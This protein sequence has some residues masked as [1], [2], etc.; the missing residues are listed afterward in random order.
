MPGLAP[1]L[2]TGQS[3]TCMRAVPEQPPVLGAPDAQ[4]P[5][6]G[7]GLLDPPDQP[8]RLGCWPGSGRVYQEALRSHEGLGDSC[9]LL[10][11]YRLL[12]FRPRIFPVS[13]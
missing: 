1:L 2:M 3:R 6:A 5:P 7:P 9:L 13:V 11:A 10:F 8:H 12:L 4:G